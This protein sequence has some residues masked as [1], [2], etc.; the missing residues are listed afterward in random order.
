M[1][2]KIFYLLTLVFFVAFTSCEQPA[3]PTG[4]SFVTFEAPSKSYV[5]NEGSTFETEYKI[6]TATNVD[7]DITLDLNVSGSLPTANYS[8]PATVTIPAGTNEGTFSVTITEN[9]LNKINGETLIIAF[10]SPDEFYSGD[11]E[12]TIKVDVFCE[13]QIAG[14]YAYSDGNG[15]AVT[16]TAGATV[17]NFVVSRDNAFTGAYSI[18]IRDQCGSL[19]VTGGALPGLGVDIA[20]S[21][22]VKPNGDIVLTYTAVGYFSDRTMTMVR[23]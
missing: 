23:Q 12:L 6:Y 16:I 2:N 18:D 15:K 9:N 8:V 17:N 7:S 19:T 20:G 3:E 22:I 11:E 4:I 13:S 5:L 1:K 10:T 14:S 21:G